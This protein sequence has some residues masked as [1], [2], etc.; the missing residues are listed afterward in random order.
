MFL[1]DIPGKP[2]NPENNQQH[3]F[4]IEFLGEFEAICEKALA[5]E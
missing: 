2:R 1:I 3:N 4:R 5:C